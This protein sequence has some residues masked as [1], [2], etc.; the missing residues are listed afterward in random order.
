MTYF[1]THGNE[2]GS[3]R[4]AHNMHAHG[5]KAAQKCLETALIQLDWQPL[6]LVL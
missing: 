5:A 6:S 4:T 3:M 2:W 1:T